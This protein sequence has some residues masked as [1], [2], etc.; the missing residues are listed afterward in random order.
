[1]RHRHNAAA[2]TVIWGCHRSCGV[3]VA[4]PPQRDHHDEGLRPN[5]VLHKVQQA[6]I[7]NDVRQSAIAKAGMIMAVAA[8]LKRKP[9]ADR[10]R[11]RRGITNIWDVHLPAGA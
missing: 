10:R 9:K 2:C 11:Y 7:A 6:W 8:L 5:G 1:M 4:K 3:L